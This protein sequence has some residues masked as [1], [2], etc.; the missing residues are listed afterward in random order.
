M[1]VT[2]SVERSQE[3]AYSGKKLKP[4]TVLNIDSK[5]KGRHK[6]KHKNKAVYNGNKD[7]Y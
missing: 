4:Y 1:K 5:C 2:H 6:L 7:N 3:T